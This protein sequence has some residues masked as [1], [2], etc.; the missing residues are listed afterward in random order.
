MNKRQKEILGIFLIITSIISI[1]SLFGHNPTEI[2]STLSSEFKINN[3]LGIYG[4]HISFYHFYLMG[5]PSIVLPLI[6]SLIGYIVFSGK[7]RL[8]LE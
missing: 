3:P 2:P 1:V 6:F 4:V 8:I 7:E 5:Y